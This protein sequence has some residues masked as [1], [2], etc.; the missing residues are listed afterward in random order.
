VANAGI[1][2][3]G[4]GGGGGGGRGTLG[5]E[6]LRGKGGGGIGAFGA[7]GFGRSGR[8]GG[9]VSR[10]VARNVAVQGTIDREAVLRVVNGHLQ[11][12]R[13]CYERALL[14]EPGLAGKVALEWTINTSGSVV[15]ARTKNSSLRNGA[16]EGCILSS[17]KTWR[18]PP[19]KGGV[20]VISYPFIFNSVGY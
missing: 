17:L 15:T 16:V 1:G 9:T 18:F 2:T 8:V 10:A 5:A 13:A 4:L 20:V 14:K 19:A 11:E 12:V 6:I 7:G 3:F